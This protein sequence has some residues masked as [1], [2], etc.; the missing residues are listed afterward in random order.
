M[1][2]KKSDS[3]SSL[4]VKYQKS[5]NKKLIPVIQK[6]TWRLP[7]KVMNHYGIK[8]FPPDIAEDILQECRTFVLFK[9]LKKYDLKK[10]NFS[11]FYFWKLKSHVRFRRRELLKRKNIIETYSIHDTIRD[12]NFENVL[13][14][15]K[16][17]KKLVM[18]N[19]DI[20]QDMKVIFNKK[21]YDIINNLMFGFTIA[22]ISNILNIP[23]SSISKYHRGIRKKI[24]KYL[25]SGL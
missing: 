15:R 24:R 1:R 4:V 9:A 6:L 20:V 17:F 12:I 3:T 2:K 10:S 23:S 14:K 5:K 7:I 22:Q 25:E 8:Y 13:S 18:T 16:E 19:E 11:T 21:Q